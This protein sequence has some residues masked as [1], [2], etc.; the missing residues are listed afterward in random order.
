MVQVKNTTKSLFG[1]ASVTDT[2]PAHAAAPAGAMAMSPVQPPV[3][4][5]LGQPA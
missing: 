3:A 4:P 5:E 1:V 2:D